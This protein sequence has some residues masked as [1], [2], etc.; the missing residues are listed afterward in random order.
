[1]SVS[2]AMMSSRVAPACVSCSEGAAAPFPFSTAFQPI[3]DL[4]SGGIF[5]YEALVRGPNGEPAS[6]VLSQIDDGNRYAFDQSSRRQAIELACRLGLIEA[7]ARLSINFMPGA[8]YNPEHCIRSS[9][10]AA[11]RSGLSPDRLIFEVV[12]Y[13]HVPDRQKLSEIFRVYRSYGI[14]NALDDFGVGHA[15]LLLFA[16]LEPEILKLDMAFTRGVQNSA[17]KRAILSGMVGICRSMGILLVAEG[18]ETDEE[19]ETMKALGVELIQGYRLGRPLFE[20]LG[21]PVL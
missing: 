8:M 10:G 16:E 17:T 14:A 2:V 7:G 20:R 1:M 12:E 13:E 3:V 6:T 18:I 19:L 21:E 9:I 15:N 4:R 11:R 5:A